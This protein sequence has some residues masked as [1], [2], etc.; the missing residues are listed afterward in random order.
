MKQTYINPAIIV[1]T[2]NVLEAYR[3]GHESSTTPMADCV[4][5]LGI[6][7]ADRARFVRAAKRLH[8]NVICSQGNVYENGVLVWSTR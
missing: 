3:A 4:R 5:D 6:S 7:K 1:G 8:W 2:K